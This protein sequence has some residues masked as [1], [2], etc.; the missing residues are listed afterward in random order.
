MDGLA[1]YANSEKCYS[2]WLD[3]NLPEQTNGCGTVTAPRRADRC[4]GCV[5]AVGR[6]RQPWAAA[7]TVSEAARRR[8]RPGR[9]PRRQSGCAALDD[10]LA[11]YRQASDRGADGGGDLPRDA[12]RGP[13]GCGEGWQQRCVVYGPGHCRPR[14]RWKHTWGRG[15]ECADGT[16]FS[17]RAAG[18]GDAGR[19]AGG[20]RAARRAYVWP[21]AAAC[22][23]GATAQCGGAH[24]GRV[25]GGLCG[26]GRG[27]AGGRGAARHG[28]QG[29][30]R[31]G[32]AT[33][34][35]AGGA[36]HR[37]QGTGNRRRGCG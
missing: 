18:E 7:P 36:G 24:R 34:V 28:D 4:G 12:S 1:D 2:L 25:A 5:G 17:G 23:P 21:R 11:N 37:E 31:L 9:G 26:S 27:T 22:V 30:R 29:G 3:E 33:G 16:L 8:L 10:A 13:I 15:E 19:V 14:Y 6:L 35:A 32:V 20:G